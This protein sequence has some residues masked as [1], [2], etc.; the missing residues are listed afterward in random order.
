MVIALLVLVDDA[1]VV[2]ES[3]YYRLQRDVKG[4]DAAIQ[5]L[6]EVFAPVTTSMLTT[7]AVFLPLM[8]L[9]DI[10]GEFMKLIPMT[11]TILYYWLVW[12]KYIGCYHP[13]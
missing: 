6:R 5:S 11:V 12:L 7:V 8:L 10:M 4:M 9:E 3:I 13:M 2:V 1:V